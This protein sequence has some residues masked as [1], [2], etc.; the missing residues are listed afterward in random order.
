VV[1]PVF[2]EDPNAPQYRQLSTSMGSSVSN[3]TD[4]LANFD[5]E[6]TNDDQLTRFTAFRDQYRSIQGSLQESE[7][8]LN[9]LMR[10]NAPMRAQREERNKYE[11]LL[12]RLQAVKTDYDNWLRDVK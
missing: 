2:S 7:N 4:I 9:L 3:S 12:R 10:S 1:F 8:R 6:F 11:Q 5:L